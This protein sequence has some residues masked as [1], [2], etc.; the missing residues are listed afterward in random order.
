MSDN[1]T[2]KD[3]DQ[4]KIVQ[5]YAAFGVSIILTVIPHLWAAAASLIMLLYVMIAAYVYRL[6][7]PADSL[8]VNHMRFITRTIWLT[9]FFAIFTLVA[10]CGYMLSYINNAA[11]TPCLDKFLNLAPEAIAFQNVITIQAL[12]DNCMNTFIHDNL[13]T[14]IVSGAIAGGP[15]LIYVAVRFAR[16]FSRALN[17]YR[18]AKPDAWF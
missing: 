4:N 12:F 9:G 3:P 5:M 15:I 11:L 13:M 16:G 10:G 7:R 8:M 6:R 17:G 18:I 14:L 1:P 2:H